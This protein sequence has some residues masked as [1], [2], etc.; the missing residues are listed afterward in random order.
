MGGL[1]WRP[2]KEQACY[3]LRPLAVVVLTVATSAC[4]IKT[5]AVNKIGD[6]L[7][8]GSTSSFARDE[9]PELVRDAIPFAL[10][11]IESLLDSSPKHQGLLTSACSSFTQY[12]YAF[13]Q[14]DADYVEA[15]DFQRAT[16]MRARAKKLY[17][18]AV[19][20]GLR[21]LEVDVPG[22]RAQLKSNPDVVLAKLTK[23]HVPLLYWT[24]SAWAA[25]FALD[26]TDSDLSTRQSEIE[27]LMRRALALDES[28]EMGSLHDFF[29]SWE[30]GHASA[31]GSIEK[32]R[33]H[34]ARSKQLSRGLRA[35]PF[36][37]LAESVS[38]T[39]NNRK[40]FEVLL[41]EA[42]AVDV[43]RAIDSRL[44]NVLSQRRAK[45]LLGRVEDLFVE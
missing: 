4:S 15:Q 13:I 5:M 44:A 1:V 10:K 26:V 37:S 39:E 12:G 18:R 42:L 3:V 22:F 11:T 16:A 21:G 17:L 32:A 29:I 24:G 19:E 30:A 8:S 36:V 2:M 43:N 35:S 40:E 7:S 28:W 41:N 38:I 23:K 20:Y 31:G 45:W 9:D 33:E 6:A 34:F 27:R 14:Q 25:A